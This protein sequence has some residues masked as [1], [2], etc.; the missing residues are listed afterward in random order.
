MAKLPSFQ[1]Y[2]GDWM[3]DPALRACTVA[4]RGLWMDMLCLMFE[5]SRRGYLQHSTGKPVTAEQLARM[6]GCPADEI[7]QLLQE[8][9]DAGVFSRSEEGTIYSRRMERDE[10]R[11]NLCGEAG[12]RGGGNPNLKGQAKGA[13][14]GEVKGAAKGSSKGSTKQKSKASSSSSASALSTASAVDTPAEP[15]ES[16]APPPPAEG[17]RQKSPLFDE[18]FEALAK[19][20]GADRKVAGGHIAKVAH[21][22]THADKPYTASE[23]LALPQAIRARGL[24]FTITIG[25]I[26]KYIGWVREAPPA[27]VEGGIPDGT[28]GRVYSEED[29]DRIIEIMRRAEKAT[30]VAKC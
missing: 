26:A 23:V 19:I 1:F 7:E 25:C 27:D 8:L 13:A 6:T 21:D 11:R 9:E 4:A 24:T 22:L 12:K 20:T 16:S 5:S 10:H 3:K 18:V 14:K 28:P 17:K 29:S 30:E 15:A 2:P